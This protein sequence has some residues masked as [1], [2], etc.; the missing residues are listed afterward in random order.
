MVQKYLKIFRKV[1]LKIENNDFRKVDLKIKNTDFRKVDLKI[2]NNDFR[3]SA[4]T[5]QAI[6]KGN[7]SALDNNI[8]EVKFGM[9]QNFWFQTMLLH[10]T[11]GPYVANMRRS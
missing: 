6:Q 7:S 11:R 4:P 3:V 8:R 2:E 5:T 10:C 1:D 9:Y